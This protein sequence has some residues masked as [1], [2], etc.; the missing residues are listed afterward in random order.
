MSILFYLLKSWL[1]GVAIAA[2]VGPVGM[3]CIRKTLE[4]G[5][6]GTI[7]VGLGAALADSIYAFIA[8]TGI[9]SVSDFLLDNELYIKILGGIFLLFLAFK[10]LKN[11]SKLP[12][13]IH[14]KGKKAVKLIY[15]VFFLTLTSP[16]TILS[17][18][19]I[20]ASI[21]GSDINHNLSLWMVLG[22]SLGSLSWMLMLGFIITKTKH[23]LSE[24]WIYRIRYVSA[25]ILGGFGVWAIYSGLIL[26][27]T[28]KG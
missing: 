21:G 7:A 25:I 12:T 1:I 22:V 10:E 11:S 4:L 9:T 13:E 23:F 14:D 5:F 15:S 27:S 8:A 16:M 24:T 6:I 17:F 26:F 19:A 20:F 2:P 28:S 3:L 18:I